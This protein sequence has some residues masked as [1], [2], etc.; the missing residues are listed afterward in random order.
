VTTIAAAT[1]RGQDALMAE[2]KL[3][4]FVARDRRAADLPRAGD[5]ART[6]ARRAGAD[7][8]CV[9]EENKAHRDRAG[10]DRDF[11]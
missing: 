3:N 5:Q 11:E 9:S 7:V 8:F 1:S 4:L 2:Y 6:P 10:V